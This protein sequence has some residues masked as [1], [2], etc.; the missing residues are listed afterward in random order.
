MLNQDFKE[1]VQSL[2]DSQARYLV[3]GGYAAILYGYPRRPKNLDIWIEA[4][5]ENARR[6]VEALEQLGLE[7]WGLTE[8]DFR[9]EDQI[10]Q[11]TFSPT[12]RVIINV[13]NE[14][15]FGACFERRT[16]KKIEDII[17]DLIPLEYLR[18]NKS[19]LWTVTGLGGA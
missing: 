1:F 2:Y 11:A 15:E 3:V 16:Q 17:V 10:I 9:H 5:A 4:S 12:R 13:L 19:N 18:I 7:S 14:I 8:V 6:M